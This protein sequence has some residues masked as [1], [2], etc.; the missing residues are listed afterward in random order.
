MTALVWVVSAAASA[1]VAVRWLRVGQREHYL[2]GAVWFGLRRWIRAYRMDAVIGGVGVLAAVAA[3]TT[4]NQMVALV[5]ILG[6]AAIPLRLPI[7]GRTSP[8]VW[9]KRFRR[10]VGLTALLIGALLVVVGSLVGVGSRLAALAP[11]IVLVSIEAALLAGLPVERRL[12]QRFVDEAV[13]RLRQVDP[14]IVAITGSYGKTSTKGY[15]RHLVDGSSPIVA[16]PA[17]FNN[18]MGLSRAVNEHL[19]DATEVFVAEM[20]TYGPGEIAEMCSWVN[21]AIAVMT[22]IGPVHLERFRSIDRIVT[23]KSE[24]LDGARIG[25][26]NVDDA[27]LADLADRYRGTA[28]IVRVSTTASRG[29]VQLIADGDEIELVVDGRPLGRAARG[30]A[31]LSNAAL[32]AAVAMELGVDVDR[33]MERIGSIPSADHRQSVYEGDGGFTIIDDTF[34]SNPTGARSAV[35]RLAAAGSPTARRIVVTP[36]MVELGRRQHA[37]NVSFAAHAAGVADDVVIVGRTN[38]RALQEGAA[39]GRA[40]VVMMPSREDAVAWVRSRLGPG[41][42]VLYEN[43]LPDHY[44]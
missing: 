4:G 14:T 9:T 37:E 29:D 27:R 19:T 13:G 17:S 33:V 43:D 22:A 34:N 36:G 40:S 38:R 7:R 3:V 2:P 6:V 24:I 26:I 31:F 16:S 35:D 5:A 8:L 32:A 12:S 15:I 21:P 41:D 44:P 11:V 28:R 39:K 25:I 18:R 42:A 10:L 23:A 20:G 1:I 30:T